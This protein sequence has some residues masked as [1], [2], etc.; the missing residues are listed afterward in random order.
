MNEMGPF[1]SIPISFVANDALV[2]DRVPSVRFLVISSLLANMEH[3][4]S[5]LHAYLEKND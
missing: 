4:L 3:E 1:H 2:S 5:F